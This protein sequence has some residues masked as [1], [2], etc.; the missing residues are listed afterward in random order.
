M[1]A[2]QPFSACSPQFDSAV[3]HRTGRGKIAAA[4]C[5]ETVGLGGKNASVLES[6]T[7]LKRFSG[8]W[9]VCPDRQ[10][11]VNHWTVYWELRLFE[12]LGVQRHYLYILNG[13]SVSDLVMEFH[14]LGTAPA[15]SVSSVQRTEL[16]RGY[17]INSG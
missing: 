4:Y 5:N 3:R 15:D 8:A 1:L 11:H 14:G 13:L 6:N 7:S 12:Y 17:N 16:T 2:L 9:L 10:S